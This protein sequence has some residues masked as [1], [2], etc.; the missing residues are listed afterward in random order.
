MP[1]LLS[2]PTEMIQNIIDQVSPDDLINFSVCRNSLHILAERRLAKHREQIKTYSKLRYN[3]C[4]GCFKV[5]DSDHPVKLL[6]EICLDEHIASYPRNLDITCCE[7]PDDTDDSYFDDILLEEELV[8]KHLDAEI[9][10]KVFDEFESTIDEKLR[11]TLRYNDKNIDIWRQRLERGTRG[12]MLSLLLLLLPN[13]E[14]IHFIDLSFEAE[15]LGDMLDLIAGGSHDPD[16][17]FGPVALTK[18][19]EVLVKGSE[20]EGGWCQILTPLAALPSIRTITANSVF[21]DPKNDPWYN[22]LTWPYEQHM[23]GLTVLN[24]QSSCLSAASFSRLLGGI[25]GLK[26]FTYDYNCRHSHGSGTAVC[27][28]ID[29]LLEHA[30]ASLESVQFTGICAWHCYGDHNICSFKNFEVLKD[31]RMRSASYFKDEEAYELDNNGESFGV[32]YDDIERLVD[33]LPASVRIVEIDGEVDTADMTSLLKQLPERK[34]KLVPHLK[35][36][37][38]L[39]YYIRDH[40]DDHTRAWATSWR[41]KLQKVGVRLIL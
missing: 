10:Q 11:K 15:P 31:I 3:G 28:I 27:T 32:W 39:D 33:L 34:A 2:L 25:K 6:R 19:S 5:E 17:T 40:E 35:S 38:F 7:F 26:S 4:R 12:A 21:G 14:K 36:I 23:S 1:S 24:L 37:N 8:A 22:D 41:K 18:L 29:I 30:K 20:E 16:V 9:V 13:L